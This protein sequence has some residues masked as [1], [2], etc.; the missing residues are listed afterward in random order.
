MVRAASLRVEHSISIVVSHSLK[1]ASLYFSILFY[2]IYLS[3]KFLLS[4]SSA[5][6]M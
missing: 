6:S 5:P 1:G 4:I 2:P 3:G